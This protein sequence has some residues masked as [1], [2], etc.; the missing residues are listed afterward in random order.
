MRRSRPNARRPKWTAS[1]TCPAARS[2]FVPAPLRDTLL[3]EMEGEG[4]DHHPAHGSGQTLDAVANIVT[5]IRICLVPVFVLAILS[6]WP[7]WVGLPGIT[8]EAKC[9]IAAGIFI[10]IS[11]TD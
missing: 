9:V 3:Y 1:P 11:C 2:A 5:L 8:M 10:L 7:E 6:P 4:Y